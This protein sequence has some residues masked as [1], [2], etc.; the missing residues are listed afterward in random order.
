M[1]G[2]LGSSIVSPCCERLG[3]L[4]CL[5]GEP[6]LIPPDDGVFCGH[7]YTAIAHSTWGTSEYTR[8]APPSRVVRTEEPAKHVLAER[9]AFHDF[10]VS[11]C[12]SVKKME[13]CGAMSRSDHRYQSFSRKSSG[14]GGRDY[15]S[16]MLM[17]A[18][19]CKSCLKSSVLEGISPPSNV[20]SDTLSSS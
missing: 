7:K 12:T 6:Q 15:S 17:A 10:K 2:D 8:A 1:Q 18:S 19:D 9:G 5:G 11:S 20:V 13:Q 14:Q 4:A 16:P 3:K